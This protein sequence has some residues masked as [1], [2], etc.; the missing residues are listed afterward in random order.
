MTRHYKF[1]WKNGTTSILS[2]VDEMDALDSVHKSETDHDYFE[3]V[4][5]EEARAA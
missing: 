4:T 2:G 5:A 1:W 3:E